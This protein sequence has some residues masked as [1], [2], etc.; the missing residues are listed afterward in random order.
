MNITQLETNYSDMHSQSLKISKS[1]VKQIDMLSVGEAK[2][3]IANSI[4]EMESLVNRKTS[5]FEKMPMFGK[6]LAK[7]KD[8]AKQHQIKSGSMTKAVDRLFHTLNNKN[9]QMMTVMQEIFK[10]REHTIQYV[11]A[12]KEQ[13]A[14]IEAYLAENDA[15]ESMDA[16]KARNLL[17]QI[18]PSILKA[19]DN[20]AT[21]AGTLNAAG[22]A[23]TKISGMLPAL[24][25]EL[26]TELAINAAATQLKEFKEIFDGTVDLIEELSHQNSKE[27]RETVLQVTDIQVTNPKHIARLEQNQKDREQLHLELQKRRER[28]EEDQ[29]DQLNLLTQLTNNQSKALAYTK[30]NEEINKA[31]GK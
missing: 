30:T 20:I 16:L 17:V 3:L 1:L 8:E 18:K 14:Q 13:E 26:Q 21:M 31:G 25:G 19:T 23:S 10:I 29:K 24:Q 12:L 22:M 4:V 9:E 6:Y 5:F 27:V 7:A 15:T 2:E 11:A 28:A